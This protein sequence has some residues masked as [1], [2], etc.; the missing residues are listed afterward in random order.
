MS[1][2]S[3]WSTIKHKKAANDARR[4]KAWSK[5]TRYVAMAARS[6]GG[7]PD[8]NARLR[9]A[10]EKAKAANVPKDTIEKAIKKGTGEQPGVVYEEVLYEGYGPGGV[11]VMCQA[12]TDNRHRT[13]PEMKK[14][15]ERCGGNL[16]AQN[17]VAWMF[18]AKGVF[19]IPRVGID[20]DRV[21][22]VA[23]ENGAD[24]VATSAEVYEVTCP[25]EAFGA[26]KAAF[27]QAE[28]PV[29]SAD[30]T[31]LAAN[32]VTPDLETARKVMRLMEALD[33]HDDITSVSSNCDIPDELM[34]ELA[35]A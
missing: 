18:N 17:S 21:M 3:K 8:A 30:V 4:S 20:E 12:V 5:L 9:L 14:L 26:L 32:M 25:P 13:S 35:G 24:D 33:E 22:E 31:S 16:G 23:L 28:I 15:F 34:A 19:A 11:A 10:I 29:Q 27:E 1:G 7:D 2:H 6:G